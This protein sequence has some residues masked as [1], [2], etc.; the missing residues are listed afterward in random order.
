MKKN[1]NLAQNIIAVF[2]ALPNEVD[3]VKIDQNL[4][5]TV[6][7]KDGKTWSEIEFT[8]KSAKYNDKTKLTAAGME[9]SKSLSLFYPGEDDSNVLDFSKLTGRPVLLKMKYSSN[10]C[11]L[12]GN[13]NGSKPR[14][15]PSFD[16]GNGKTGRILKF[17]CKDTHEAYPLTD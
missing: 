2:Y 7:F 11:K 17:A 4:N 8:P 9:H 6:N 13:L 12:V 3:S 15:L 14:L 16:V 10:Q 1:K 5:S